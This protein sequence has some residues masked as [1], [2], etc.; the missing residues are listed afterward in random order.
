MRCDG[1]CESGLS[2]KRLGRGFCATR[3]SPAQP[4]LCST[5]QRATLIAIRRTNSTAAR[6]AHDATGRHAATAATTPRSGLTRAAAR[7]PTP[8]MPL[9]HLQQRSFAASAASSNSS[10]ASKPAESA[11]SSSSTGSSGSSG[12]ESKQ[13]S[14]SS[15]SGGSSDGSSSGGSST[16]GG[17]YFRSDSWTKTVGTIGAIANWTIPLAG[18]THMLNAKDPATTIDP[19]MTSG[20]TASSTAEK[21][22][23]AMAAAGRTRSVRA[24]MLTSLC[25]CRCVCFAAL[26]LAVYSVFFMRWALAITPANYPLLVCH[27]SNEVVQLAQLGRYV[28]A[29]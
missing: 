15:S 4:R 23:T 27:V 7:Q 11:A 20:Q 17:G 25:A 22:A 26:A 16:G 24:T 18:I 10:G 14:S 2:A 28:N 3:R 12:E 1:V 29:V 19:V 5:M 21:A 8:M 9:M 6:T 13:Q